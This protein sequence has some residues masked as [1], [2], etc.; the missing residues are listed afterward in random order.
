[1]PHV[2]ATSVIESPC[3][4]RSVTLVVSLPKAET[5]RPCPELIAVTELT[6][7]PP[8]ALFGFGGVS[9]PYTVPITGVPGVVESVIVAGPRTV[10]GYDT[11]TAIV[12]VPK[13]LEPRPSLMKG[14][15]T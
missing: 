13:L 9:R 12:P 1:M 8:H 11:Y 10:P 15:R 2:P 4:K 14:S 5:A 3:A 7:E 6:I